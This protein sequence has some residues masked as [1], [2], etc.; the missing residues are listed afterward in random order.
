VIHDACDGISSGQGLRISGDHSN[1]YSRK[2]NG[3]GNSGDGQVNSFQDQGAWNRE[4][5]QYST[6]LV[7]HHS[8]RRRFDIDKQAVLCQISELD[9]FDLFPIVLSCQFSLCIFY[10]RAIFVRLLKLI[11]SHADDA[12]SS[13]SNIFFEIFLK[14]AST[15]QSTI[16]RL[17][18]LCFKQGQGAPA[19]AEKLF[20]SLLQ[21]VFNR[22]LLCVF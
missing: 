17:L 18:A 16:V 14:N 12:T 22:S 19:Q 13:T 1:G 21:V 10:A 9:F 4:I 5:Q 6:I 3:I 15:T 8:A 7:G 11:C 2:S 20:P